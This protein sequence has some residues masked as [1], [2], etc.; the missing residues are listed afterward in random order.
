MHDF[1]TNR[2]CMHN[3]FVMAVLGSSSTRERHLACFFFWGGDIC[4]L[5]LHEIFFRYRLVYKKVKTNLVSL[6]SIF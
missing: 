3:T 4:D 5:F 2:L 1:L 6:F